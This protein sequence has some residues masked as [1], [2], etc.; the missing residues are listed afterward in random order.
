MRIGWMVEVF[1]TLYGDEGG[2][3][4]NLLL[5][6]YERQLGW[7]SLLRLSKSRD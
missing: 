2:D 6:F 5:D 1:L 7:K 4:C 3:V